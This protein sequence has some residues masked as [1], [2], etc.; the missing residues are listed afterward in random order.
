MRLR[1]VISGGQTGADHAGLLNAKRLGL[2]TGGTAPKDYRTEAGNNPGL[3]D[4]GLVESLSY[5]YKV[6]TVQNVKDA[7]A[8]LWFGNV[9]SPG[10]WCTRN[11]TIRYQKPFIENPDAERMRLI[12]QTYEVIN[13]AGNRFSKNPDVLRRVNEAFDALQELL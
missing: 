9:S 4:L 13:V 3:R 12:A 11:A 6:R 2:E 10:Y 7:E 5:D 1:K 8:T